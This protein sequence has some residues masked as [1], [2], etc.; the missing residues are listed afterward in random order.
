MARTLAS[1]YLTTLLIF[2]VS[3]C[4]SNSLDVA[5]ICDL[6]FKRALFSVYFLRIQGIPSILFGK[7]STEV[8]LLCFHYLVGVLNCNTALRIYL[9]ATQTTELTTTP[10]YSPKTV[11]TENTTSDGEPKPTSGGASNEGGNKGQKEQPQRKGNT[12]MVCD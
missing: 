4:R 9:L 1:T 5:V 8:V 10:F 3:S 2:Q 11:H 7:Y 6:N 12:S